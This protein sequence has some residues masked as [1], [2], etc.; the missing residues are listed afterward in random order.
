MLRPD[1]VDHPNHINWPTGSGRWKH[2]MAT[3]QRTGYIYTR[4][5]QGQIV[6]FDPISRV[7]DLTFTTPQSGGSYLYFDPN[8]PELLYISYE[9]RHAIWVFNT[10]TRELSLFAGAHDQSG[11]RGGDRLEARFNTPSQLVIDADGIMYVADRGNHAIRIITP[12][13]RVTTIIGHGTVAGYQDGNPDD[14]LFDNPRGLAIDKHG[15]IF[16]ADFGNNVV[17]KLGVQ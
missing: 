3:C 4:F 2:S 5:Y 6:R 9:D 17:R 12:D 8:N 7:G 14:A 15:T 16:V 1:P 10:I 11:Y 13:G